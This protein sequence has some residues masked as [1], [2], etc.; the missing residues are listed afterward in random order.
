MISDKMSALE[1]RD[2]CRS[3]GNTDLYGLGN[4]LGVYFQMIAFIIA[5]RRGVSDEPRGALL[6]SINVALLATFIAVVKGIVNETV[7][8]VDLVIIDSLIFTQINLPLFNFDLMF[9]KHPVTTLLMA[10]LGFGM[11]V[12]VAWF[13]FVGIGKLPR[14]DCPDDYGFFFSKASLYGW[15]STLWKVLSVGTAIIAGLVFLAG[16]LP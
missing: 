7:R 1:P 3:D 14:T 4:R 11:Q 9:I 12:L 10:P 6:T 15:F 8:T 13:W 5:L 2:V 16:R